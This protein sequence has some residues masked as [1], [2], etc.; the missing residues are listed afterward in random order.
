MLN[1]SIV[2]PNMSIMPAT[3]TTN[4]LDHLVVGGCD[5][6]EL[7]QQF[8]TP[9]WIIDY[10]TIRLAA[11]GC[12]SGM[13][14][15]PNSTVLYA[16]KAFM[17]LAL[18]K[19]VS[20]LGLG[21]DVVSE[22]ELYTAL[23]ADVDPRNIYL[24]GNNKSDEE[25]RLAIANPGV[26]VVVDNGAELIRLSK[27]VQ[28]SANPAPVPV[29]VRVTPGVE[30][31][32]HHYIKTGQV[33]S[34]FGIPINDV[35]DFVRKCIEH[36]EF[37]D[38][39]GIH[40][41]IGSQTH[42]IEPYLEIVDI[43][44]DLALDLKES[45][46]QEILILDVGGGLGIAYTVKDQPMPITEWSQ[47]LCQRVKS[48]FDERGLRQPHLLL[49]PGRSIVGPAG[50]SLYRAGEVKILSDG[51]RCVALDGGMADNPRPSMYGAV[52]TSVI[53]DR[54]QSKGGTKTTLVGR[55]CE[56]GD[57]IIKDAGIPAEQGDLIAVF[58]TGAY[59]Y[60]MSSNY[61]RTGRPACVLVK[62]G[63]AELIIERETNDDLLRMDRIPK[64]LDD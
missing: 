20:G 17:C 4:E 2:S 42:K 15:Y 8:G 24:H 7:A 52:Y 50:V 36:R 13:E 23:K 47:L 34:K 49:E 32:T 14:S 38:F 45:L 54:M 53:A 29:M 40:A 27:L 26:K 59:N 5:T 64:W 30:P 28:A 61:N 12:K 37:I 46:A 62:D 55:Y 19:I 6:V 10:E 35:H 33:D 39:Q 58:S 44:A 1:A 25:L 21:V 18:C 11:L 3:A 60:S 31:D 56:S 41:H 48:A 51:A 43:L 63:Q 22:G 9:L 57:I 16:A